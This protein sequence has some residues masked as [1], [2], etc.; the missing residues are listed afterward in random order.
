M[1]S[2]KKKHMKQALSILFAVLILI[3]CIPFAATAEDNTTD[4]VEI[5]TFEDLYDVRYDLTAKYKLMN[6]IDM[7]EWVKPGGD[8]DYFG[9]G[10]NPIGSKNVY[11]DEAFSG[12]F[13]GNDH[14]I[15]GLCM[16]VKKF[17]SGTSS[18]VYFGLFARVS[19]TIR[20]LTV[21][22]EIKVSDNKANYAGGITGFLNDSGLIENCVN[23]V[24]LTIS[25]SSYQIAGGIVGYSYGIVRNCQNVSS[26]S[27]STNSSYSYSAGVVGYGCNTVSTA[28]SNYAS[29]YYYARVNNSI[30]TG[31]IKATARTA[32]CTA[33]SGIVNYAKEARNCYNLGT[34]ETNAQYFD[35][36]E[37]TNNSFYKNGIAHRSNSIRNCYNI[38]LVPAYTSEGSYT[39]RNYNYAI[40]SSASTSCF[41]I[42]G[43]GNSSTGATEQ[44]DVQMKRQITFQ[45]WDFD[46]V[47]TMDGREDYFY[48]ELRDVPLLLPDDFKT[49][50]SGTLKIDGSQEVDSVLTANIDNLAPED[51]TVSYSWK[52]DDTEVST[53]NSYQINAEDIGKTLTLTVSGTGDFKG[54]LTASCVL[55]APHVHTEEI[56]PA[57]TPTCTETGLT[58]GLMCSECGEIL[59][60]QAVV[61]ANGHT[62]VTAGAYSATCLTDGF[63]GVTY[64]SVCKEI[65][66]EGE[67]VAAAGQHTPGEAVETVLKAATCGED[68][69]K[70]ITVT[71]T[72][73]GE[74]LSDSTETIPATEEHT[75]DEAEEK[76][77]VAATC[78]K[79]GTKLVTVKCSGCGE[80]LN[81][82]TEIILATGNHTPGETEETVLAEATCGQNGIKLLS[83]KCSVCGEALSNATESIAATNNHTPDEAEELV[84]IEAT[85]EKSGTKLVTV[86]CS[87]CGK[88]LSENTATIPAT[89]IHTPGETLIENE[90]AATCKDK[91]S[92]DEVVYCTVCGNEISRKTTETEKLRHVNADPVVENKREATCVAA[93]SY[94]SVVY[95]RKCGTQLSRETIVL[96]KLSHTP[97]EPVETISRAATCDE[98]GET[99]ITVRC[100][101]CGTVISEKT[102]SVPALGHTDK[103]NDGKCDTC[104]QQMTGGD[105]CK[106]CGKVHD[107]AFGWLVSF[108]HSI[109]AIFKR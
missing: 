8:Y 104:K 50:I 15:S 66:N 21:S 28:D 38:G 91:G 35:K 83:V 77:L 36:D 33:A 71:C 97:G 14:I 98:K 61:P 68:G 27:S 79:D 101:V 34:I 64:C 88:T 95:C 49:P 69:L 62:P 81:E 22:G 109:L 18:T 46:T 51:A 3:T 1:K 108:F 53:T 72:A 44:S 41:Y 94:D 90:V 70:Q 7:T 93:G 52:I 6:D 17:P 54:T 60:A 67:S 75:A 74:T 13:D 32:I 103:N 73:C 19:G 82:N 20:N 42:K 39:I 85:C 58:E 25:G 80:T 106:Y 11:A 55:G 84:L 24:S 37:Y 12:I 92:Y 48:P 57:V 102:E 10:W 5:Y 76:V 99:K 105:H 100:K 2:K 31:E 107:G 4:W 87:V 63:T 16:N 96:N 29:S 59:T 56:I 30:N 23:R 43:S 47:W 86:K 45:S 89:G 40:S 26:I 65:L 78:G 9:Q